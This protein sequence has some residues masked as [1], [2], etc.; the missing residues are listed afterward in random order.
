M[1]VAK[2]S[3]QAFSVP[4]LVGAQRELAAAENIKHNFLETPL[5]TF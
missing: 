1:G 3:A 2:R 5:S 4:D